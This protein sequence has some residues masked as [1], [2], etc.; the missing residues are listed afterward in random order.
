MAKATKANLSIAK[1]VLQDLK[2]TMVHSLKFQKSKVPSEINGCCD[3][4][5]SASEDRRSIT[6]V[7][8]V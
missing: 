3:S 4:D 8:V 6:G 7:S 5:W 2:G 1:H